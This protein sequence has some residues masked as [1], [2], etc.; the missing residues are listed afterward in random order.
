MYINKFVKEVID[1]LY[2]FVVGFAIYLTHFDTRELRLK[3]AVKHV[4]LPMVKPLVESG[5]KIDN[6][7]IL[8]PLVRCQTGHRYFDKILM[9]IWLNEQ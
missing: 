8:E 6:K 3:Y 1:F 5:A 9:W 7:P 2:L 4:K